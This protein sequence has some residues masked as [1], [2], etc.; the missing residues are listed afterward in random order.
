[1][2]RVRALT[3]GTDDGARR[4]DTD[5]SQ[6]RAFEQPTSGAF[7]RRRVAERATDRVDG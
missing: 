4:R 7:R 1:V 3:A 5:C 2:L 6:R